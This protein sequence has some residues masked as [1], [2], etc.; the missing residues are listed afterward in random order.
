MAKTKEKLTLESPVSQLRG[1][2]KQAV[3]RCDTLGV[4]NI[5]SLLTYYP[6]R[7]NDYRAT[8]PEKVPAKAQITM[9]GRVD[10]IPNRKYHGRRNTETFRLAYDNDEKSISVT[11]FNCA[12]LV[13]KIHMNDTVIVYGKANKFQNW[14][15]DT[16]TSINGAR[17]KGVP[18]HASLADI[19]KPIYPSKHGIK[20]SKIQRM[21]KDCYQQCA[22]L[23]KEIVPQSIRK[24]Y[25]LEPEARVVHD[26]QFPQSEKAER[27]ARRTAKFNE[28][29]TYEMKLAKM[30]QDNAEK[31]G[32]AVTY[33]PKLL[34]RFDDSLPFQMTKGQLRSVYEI[35]TNLRTP[36]QMNRL[37]QGDVGSGKTVVSAFGILATISAGY[38][39]AIMIP[40][41]V[42]GEQHYKTFSRLFK[43]LNIHILLLT[44]DMKPAEQ[45]Q[46]QKK[47][48]SGDAQLVIGT[49]S[50]IQPSVQFKRLGLAV[51]DE[52]HKFGVSQRKAL[53]DK[54]RGVN[55]LSMTATPIP[56][57]LA[58][59]AYGDMD[60]SIIDT[61]PKGRK[62]VITKWIRPIQFNTF[63]PFIKQLLSKGQQV[64]CVVPLVK[65]TDSSDDKKPSKRKSQQLSLDPQL[66]AHYSSILLKSLEPQ[67]KSD[68]KKPNNDKLDSVTAYH[69]FKKLFNGYRVGLLHGQMDDDEK[70]KVLR[71]FKDG[72]I[73]FLVS[74]TVVEVGVDAPKATMMIIENA[75]NFGLSSLHQLRGRVGRNSI[76][77]YCL[78]VASPKTENG[79]KRMRVMERTNNGFI[80]SQEDLK[81]RGAGDIFGQNQSGLPSFSVADP[82]ADE[83]I[84]EC[85]R[86]EAQNRIMRHPC[87]KSK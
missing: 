20:Q 85:A 8:D 65:Q 44:S 60:I 48:A 26:M 33:D 3:K 15:G 68:K 49:D 45:R 41:S 86:R 5:Q 34:R 83:V 71:D 27:L 82:I 13:H 58:I 77:S 21:V 22:P 76:Q 80:V 18:T 67:S 7:Y 53:V 19:V 35:V 47:I 54:G 50:L 42:L 17:I 46:A 1:F 40:T 39:A 69:H 36:T 9:L 43:N 70:D 64:Y 63:V 2:G 61:L 66:K 4:K 38:Q 56:R 72:K 23:I 62:P 6:F 24:K 29:Y 73:Q 74:T 84:L 59:T 57:T 75:D 51:I 37:L 14:Q 12:W 16:V 78:L 28:F 31:R 79:R 25:R 30:K 10:S 55:E 32:I 87:I 52:Q 11:F 81:I